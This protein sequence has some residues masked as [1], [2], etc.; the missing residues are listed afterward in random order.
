MITVDQATP[1]RQVAYVPL[2]ARQDEKPDGEPLWQHEDIAYGFVAGT[3]RDLK[4]VPFVHCRW[5]N[6]PP[7]EHELRTISNGEP[8]NLS[9]LYLYEHHTQAKILHDWRAC[10]GGQLPEEF[11]L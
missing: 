10:D 2:H 6:R 4:G 1:A 5:Y 3:I 9:D 11:G 7:R 8:T